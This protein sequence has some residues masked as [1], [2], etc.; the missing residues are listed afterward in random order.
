M[1]QL[2][3]IRHAKS[4]WDID[5]QNDFDRT[6]NE[7]GHKDAPTMAQRM[8]D[9]KIAIDLIVSS[10]A[11][12]AFTTAKYFANI[13]GKSEKDILKLEQLYHAQ[14]QTFYETIATLK[15]EYCNVAI[16]SHNP[17]ITAFV[18]E[19]TKTIIDDMPTCGIFA[20]T[21]QTDKWLNFKKAKK[22]FLFF[23]YPKSF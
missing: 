2:L 21:A 23:D 7:R 8:L 22:T 17:G 1:K 13:Y 12:R 4:S 14:P 20:I 18:N 16:F 5:I 15:D 6:L 11:M 10:A 19:L 9:K 3:I